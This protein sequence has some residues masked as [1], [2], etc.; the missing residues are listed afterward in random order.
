M[1]FKETTLSRHEGG[2]SASVADAL[3]LNELL[4]LLNESGEGDFRARQDAFACYLSAS[5]GWRD[6]VKRLGGAFAQGEGLR[7]N[8]A[9]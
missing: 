9:D 5:D 1:G 2:V 6:A 8:K 7:E 3:S 4:Q